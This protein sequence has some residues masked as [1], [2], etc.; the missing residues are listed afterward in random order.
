MYLYAL[1]MY[2][3]F[4]CLVSMIACDGSIDMVGYLW[5]VLGG[6]RVCA[7]PP[8]AAA[9]GRW[10]LLLETPHIL[11]QVFRAGIESSVL[12]ALAEHHTRIVEPSTE[13]A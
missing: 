2:I 7:V 13:E 12:R 10:V 9:V 5:I 3:L 4:V 11:L 8:H 6:L 1:C